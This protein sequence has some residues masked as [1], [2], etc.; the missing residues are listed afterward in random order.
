MVLQPTKKLLQASDLPK[1][2]LLLGISAISLLLI[3]LFQRFN[4]FEFMV[5]FLGGDFQSI[6][7]MTSF[8]VNKTFRFLLNDG[9][10]I[11]MIYAIFYQRK[12]VIMA[13]YVQLF[14]LFVL[15]PSYLI[16]KSYY[17]GYN[18]P[19]ISHLHR[20]TLNPV[21]LM[22]LIPAFFY[23]LTLEQKRHN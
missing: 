21:L 8:A 7:K 2:S 19:L 12:F 15:L 13:V 14:G 4:Y 17:P 10:A 9:M 6:P 3:F 1:R 11:L 18:G 20:L 16:L 5:T 22:L 23:Q